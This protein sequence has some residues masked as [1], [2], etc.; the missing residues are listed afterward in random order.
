MRAEGKVCTP[1]IQIPAG[2]GTVKLSELRERVKNW[3]VGVKK[4]LSGIAGE[5][6]KCHR[7]AQLQLLK[8]PVCVSTFQR[9]NKRPKESQFICQ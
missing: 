8:E 7:C 4:T 9:R 6:V 1:K 3:K 2:K 5:Y